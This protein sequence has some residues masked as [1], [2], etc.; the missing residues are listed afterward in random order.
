VVK[1]TGC[2]GFGS[3]RLF[4]DAQLSVTNSRE[5]DALFWPPQALHALQCRQ[6]LGV[7]AHSFNHSTAVA[8][9][10]ISP[11]LNLA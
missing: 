4:D 1:I 6:E 5:S 3:Y 2:T 10:G 9:S 8:A 7:V 11:S